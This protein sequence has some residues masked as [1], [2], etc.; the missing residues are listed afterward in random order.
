MQTVDKPP[1]RAADKLKPASEC[2]D[3]LVVIWLVGLV[4]VIVIVFLQFYRHCFTPYEPAV[5]SWCIQT[6]SPLLA[7]M[8]AKWTGNTQANATVRETH[9]HS[10][11]VLS[12][13]YLAGAIIILY[14]I[15]PQGRNNAEKITTMETLS[16]VLGILMI[17][18]SVLIG[19]CFGFKLKGKPKASVPHSA[20]NDTP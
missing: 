10:A 18:L 6:F 19:T 5:M 12:I 4:T 17:P 11:I 14:L 20:T 2:Q 13:L 15:G 7:G 8:L 9:Y 1:K 3:R 16:A